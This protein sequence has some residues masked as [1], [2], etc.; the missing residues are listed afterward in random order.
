MGIMFGVGWGCVCAMCG[1]C[2]VCAVC[3][4]CGVCGV[5]CAGGVGFIGGV[6]NVCGVYVEFNKSV[7]GFE[8]VVFLSV[9]LVLVFALRQGFYFVFLSLK[10]FGTLM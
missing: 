8:F 4:V 5:G 1:V 10:G 9:G 7:V 6:C 3:C 2:A